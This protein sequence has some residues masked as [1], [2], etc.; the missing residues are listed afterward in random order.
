[1]SMPKQQTNVTNARFEYT[2][3]YDRLYMLSRSLFY[4]RSCM[5]LYKCFYH[6]FCGLKRDMKN[7]QKQNHNQCRIKESELNKDVIRYP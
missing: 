3:S 2:Y 7:K 1:M 6:F 5:I 4:L